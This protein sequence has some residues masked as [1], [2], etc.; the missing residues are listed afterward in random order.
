[1]VAAVA[2]LG[3]SSASYSWSA[4]AAALLVG[5]HKGLKETLGYRVYIR[6]RLGRG[7]GLIH[8]RRWADPTVVIE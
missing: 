1:M 5:Y 2:S 4:R 7:L 6:E 8:R 3:C